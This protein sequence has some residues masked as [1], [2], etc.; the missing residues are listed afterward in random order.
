MMHQTFSAT[1]RK[2]LQNISN[3]FN[4][5]SQSLEPCLPVL[6]S[7]KRNAQKWKKRLIKKEER[8]ETVYQHAGENTKRADRVYAWGYAG[9]GALGVPTFVEPEGN[10][11]PVISR[12]RPYRLRRLD[13]HNIKVKEVACGFGFTLYMCKAPQGPML[14]G[15]GINTDSQLG[16]MQGKHGQGRLDYVISPAE[17]KLPFV[18][19]T[20]TEVRLAAAGRAHSVLVTDKEGAFSLGNNSCGQCGRTV[21]EG[22]EFS[23]SQIINKVPVPGNVEQVVCGNE[24]TLFLTEDGEV[25]SCGLGADGQTGL[26][27]YNSESK[28]TLV[29]G[30]IE[31]EKIVQL[32][33]VAETVMAISEKGDIFGW[34]NNEYNQ[35]SVITEEMQVNVPRHLPFKN[36][37]KVT[38]VAVGGTIC[39]I[40]NDE[41]QVYVWGYGVLGKGPKLEQSHSPTLIPEILFG[42]NEFTSDT[43]VVDLKAGM[44]YFVAQTDTNELYSWGNNRHG[45]LGLGHADAQFFPFKVSVPAEVFKFACGVDHMVALTKAFA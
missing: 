16:Y 37:G 22:E 25:Y 15:C 26:G 28:P 42:R 13:E 34:G 10:Q 7:F 9:T 6:A 17:I 5:G 4:R 27:H 20:T 19:P 39:G 18:H 11:N 40:L 44:H 35:L 45:H 24:H 38:R 41:G 23:G 36:V 33:S 2:L 30:D 32:A 14:L 3:Q 31:K 29:K 21:V 43:T 12:N 8:K 1:S